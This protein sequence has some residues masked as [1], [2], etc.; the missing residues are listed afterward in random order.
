MLYHEQ[1]EDYRPLFWMQ[2]RPVYLSTLL[3]ALHILAF[4]AAALFISYF[5]LDTVIAALCLDPEAVWHGEVW[6]LFSYVAFDPAFFQQR[7]LWFLISIALFW[8]FGR[9]VEQL[10]GRKTYLM[11]YLALVFIPAILF[12][13]LSLVYV[14]PGA[15]F[16][17]C[18]DVFFGVFVAFATV[19]PGAIPSLWIP[20]SARAW[21]WIL[22]GISSLIHIA[23][24]DF[25]GLF[26]LWTSSGVGYGAMHLIG[27]DRSNWFAN[28]MEERRA[29]RLARQRNLKVLQD[30][31]TN[32][33]IDAILDKISKHGVGSLD[34]R[35]RAALER[36]RTKLLQRDQR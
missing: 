28:W 4:I 6:R 2:G 1:S 10:V 25:A 35:E 30:Q 31:Q 11:L 9:E 20:I 3:V 23:F 19:Y 14:V 12:C 17:N 21:M 5:G 32:E 34:A 13:L 22:L 7:S 24:R 29:Q 16:L 18:C 33:S 15:A 8:F 26:M 36:A 27:G